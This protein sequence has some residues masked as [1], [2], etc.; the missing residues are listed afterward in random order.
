MTAPTTDPADTDRGGVRDAKRTLRLQVLARRDLMSAESRRE[1]GRAIV[2]AL[3]ARPDFNA[4]TTLLLTLPFGSEWDTRPL[5]ALALARGKTVGVPQVNSVT[6]SLDFAIVRDLERDVAPGY[7]AIPE[8]LGHCPPL[9]LEAVAWVLVPGVAF[10]RTGQR[11]GY[12]GGYYDRLL[13][14]L[15]AAVSRVAGAFDL[16][17]VER[18]PA[19]AHDL[20]VDAIVTETRTIA[21]AR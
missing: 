5:A 3:A 17:L 15:P 1:A 6:H 13:S 11:V 21:T 4:A 14:S 10:D 18:V 20:A 2:A 19:A 7:G 9:A 8:P 16:Q 12:G